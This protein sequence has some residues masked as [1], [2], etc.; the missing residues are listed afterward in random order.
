MTQTIFYV[1]DNS[2]PPK[3]VQAKYLQISGQYVVD[4]NT[5]VASNTPIYADSLGQTLLQNTNGYLIVPADYN[6]NNTIVSAQLVSSIMGTLGYDVGLSIMAL[7]FSPHGTDTQDLQRTYDNN[8]INGPGATNGPFVTAFIDAASY[9]LGV[10]SYNANIPLIYT[11][12]AGGLYNANFGGGNTS[13]LFS[14]TVINARSITAGYLEA[15]EADT[16]R[17]DCRRSCRK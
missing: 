13:G 8:V 1:Q 6:P 5:T 7:E 2:H 12:A 15:S 17:T 9:N 3:Y 11:L 4:P 14:N 10:F 16:S